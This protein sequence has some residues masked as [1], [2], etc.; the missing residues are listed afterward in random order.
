VKSLFDSRTNPLNS[1]NSVFSDNRATFEWDGT[2]EHGEWV[3]AG[4]YI[5]HL[6]VRSAG[7]S[8]TDEV[9]IPVVVAT[10]LDR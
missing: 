2:N 9:H 1:I 5:A 4:A 3:S 6:Q 7:G 10:R 8:G